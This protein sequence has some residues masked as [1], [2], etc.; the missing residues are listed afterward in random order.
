MD[1]L[2]RGAVKALEGRPLWNRA[3][4][5]ELELLQFGARIEGQDFRGR[6]RTV[7]EWAL[8]L[9]GGWRIIAQGRVLVGYRDYWIAG[10]GVSDEQ[11]DP[12]SPGSSRRDR[13]MDLF[14]SHGED[15]HVVRTADLTEMGD[16]R[17]VFADG[18]M[19]EAFA[20]IGFV[21]AIDDEA[22]EECWRLFSPGADTEHLVIEA[23]G[24]IDFP[25]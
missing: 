13:L 1:N 7:G 14:M 19:L 18:C 25:G 23:G 16:L 11:F 4:A 15:V 8:H 6:P 3:R 9:S 24:V 5:V 2:A 22:P 21:K 10:E 20:D 12:A 17:L